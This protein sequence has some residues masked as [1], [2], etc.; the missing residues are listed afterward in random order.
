T[1]QSLYNNKTNNHLH[2]NSKLRKII[3]DSKIMHFTC[4]PISME[5][6][7]STVEKCIKAAK[8]NN[9]LIGFDPNYHPK[10]WKKNENG[11]EYIKSIM[12]YV[13]IVKP[14]LD[15]AERLFG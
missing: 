15:D 9:L 12:P 11:V 4:W 3:Q 1:M 8:A 2:Y 13:D 6:A 14:S 5:P 7:R 10:L